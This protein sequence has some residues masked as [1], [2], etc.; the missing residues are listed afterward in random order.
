MCVNVCVNVVSFIFKNTILRSGNDLNLTTSHQEQKKRRYQCGISTPHKVVNPGT[1]ESPKLSYVSKSAATTFQLQR[2]RLLTNSFCILCYDN[3]L[4]VDN[5]FLLNFQMF[6]WRNRPFLKRRWC[7]ERENI[8]T[9]LKKNKTIRPDSIKVCTRV[10]GTQVFLQIRSL[11]LRYDVITTFLKCDFRMDRFGQMSDLVHGPFVLQEP[12]DI[13][14]SLIVV[15]FCCV[16]CCCCC[17]VCLLLPENKVTMIMIWIKVQTK[18]NKM[19]FL[20]WSYSLLHITVYKVWL[21]S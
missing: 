11:Y 14:N 21:L 7:W 12:G 8:F 19:E 16:C 6:K 4:N 3:C 1:T 13:F 18:C 20:P 9:K 2:R 15:V 17:F 5:N 10:K